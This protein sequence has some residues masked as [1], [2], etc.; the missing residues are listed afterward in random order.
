MGT[1]RGDHQLAQ[2]GKARR[3]HAAQQG[4]AEGSATSPG[5]AMRLDSLEPFSRPV[6]LRN[7]R[8]WALQQIICCDI[9]HRQH[10]AKRPASRHSRPRFRLRRPSSGLCRCHPGRGRHLWGV[11]VQCCRCRHEPSPTTTRNPPPAPKQAAAQ[12]QPR[13]V[14]PADP[15]PVRQRWRRN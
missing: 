4:V 11:W 6:G 1:P 2:R 3:R 7:H 9:G 15:H 8:T 10:G 12:H 13:T 14:N 5:A